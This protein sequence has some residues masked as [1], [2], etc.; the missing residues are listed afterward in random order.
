MATASVQAVSSPPTPLQGILAE[1]R[2]SRIFPRAICLLA[3]HSALCKQ[4]S[5]WT[6]SSAAICRAPHM[7]WNILSLNFILHIPISF[8]L[9]LCIKAH[10]A[11]SSISPTWALNMLAEYAYRFLDYTFT[12]MQY[13]ANEYPSQMPKSLREAK[14]LS[15]LRAFGSSTE[16]L[17]VGKEAAM[18]LSWYPTR[19][20]GCP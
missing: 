10:N 17:H 1:T 13:E 2:S 7:S 11:I 5:L 16:L 20:S 6:Q 19:E 18:H 8:R 9:L 12:L 15:T 14:C 4:H 3:T